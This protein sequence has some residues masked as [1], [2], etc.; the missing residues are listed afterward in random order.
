FGPGEHTVRWRYLRPNTTAGQNLDAG[1]L[2][3]VVWT[4]QD[5]PP[6]A[7][8]LGQPPSPVLTGGP[9]DVAM[10]AQSEVV[11]E[12]SSAVAS[13][14]TANS[15]LIWLEQRSVM[16]P[17]KLDFA[18]KAERN[19]TIRLR[20]NGTIVRTLS[21][22][23]AAAGQ[24]WTLVEVDLPA[25]LHL[26]RWEH[27]NTTTLG[28]VY[29]ASLAYNSASL[30]LSQWAAAFGLTGAAAAPGKDPNSDGASLLAEFAS[31]LHPFV[32]DARPLTPGTGLAGLPHVGVEGSGADARLRIE[33][34]RRKNSPSL[35]YTAEFCSDPTS[36]G[37][38]GW[39][40]A[41]SPEQVFPINDV[42]ERVVIKDHL[43]FGEAGRRFGRVR[44][45]YAGP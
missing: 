17:G 19:Q 30:T 43:S 40:A 25:G 45:H 28:S 27:I 20:L 34:L 22:G 12:G 3:A 26:L 35:T 5:P 10:R 38:Q 41:V 33:F 15:Q 4:P 16:G 2:D 37:S 42:W 44:F 6:L 23:S 8:A 1:F 18:W 32:A 7:A 11:F 9:A 31:N 36:S 39:N 21:G 13:T 14:T 29:L 24:D